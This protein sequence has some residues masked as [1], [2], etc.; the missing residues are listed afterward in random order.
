M[1]C[2]SKC[3]WLTD[4]LRT[5]VFFLAWKKKTAPAT[6]ISYI[7]SKKIRRMVRCLPKFSLAKNNIYTSTSMKDQWL[8][9]SRFIHSIKDTIHSSFTAFDLIRSVRLKLMTQYI[10]WVLW[11]FIK[12]LLYSMH[13]WILDLVRYNIIYIYCCFIIYILLWL[14]RIES[15]YIMNH[16]FDALEFHQVVQILTQQYS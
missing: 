16:Q 12:T 7:D 1:R 14:A 6:T 8:I 9:H 10:D 3:D 13:H 2:N 15:S 4:W 11:I 5:K